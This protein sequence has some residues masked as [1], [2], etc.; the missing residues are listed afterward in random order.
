MSTAVQERQGKRATIGV[1]LRAVENSFYGRE[2]GDPDWQR[3]GVRGLLQ[4]QI[5]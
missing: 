2:R 4:K 1:I 3:C 5:G